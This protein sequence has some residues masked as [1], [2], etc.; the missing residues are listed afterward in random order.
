MRWQAPRETG[1]DQPQT[2]HK[3]AVAVRQGP[4]QM[5]VI[6]QDADRDCP[7]RIPGHYV[8]IGSAQRLNIP[9]ER[10]GSPVMKAQRK[11]VSAARHIKTTITRHG[12]NISRTFTI[13]NPVGR[14]EIPPSKP[15]A[16][17]SQKV[18]HGRAVME[19]QPQSRQLSF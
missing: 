12:R 8:S 6:G 9:D 1:L 11:G 18:R 2:V 14:D 17:T 13:V 19:A 16:D 10:I 4:E 5:H 15:K 3:I 7:D